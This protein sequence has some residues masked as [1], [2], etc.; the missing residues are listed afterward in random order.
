MICVDPLHRAKAAPNGF[1][2]A[3]QTVTRGR[4]MNGSRLNIGRKLSIKPTKSGF[5]GTINTRVFTKEKDLISKLKGSE[6]MK[7]ALDKGAFI[8]HRAHMYDAGLDLRAQTDG[9]ILPKCRKTFDTGA[10]MEIP[11]TCVGL[12]TSKSGLMAKHGITCRGTIDCG[13]TGSIKVV[14]IN[15][16]WLPVKISAGQKIAQIVIMPIYLPDLDIV[17]ALDRTER[18]NG[19]FGSTGAF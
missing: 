4:S 16:G 12:M 6:T 3:A 8:P 5:F 13:Y 17:D 9:W 18:G 11:K 7:I 15:H 19:G 2:D 10:H 14:L 1:L